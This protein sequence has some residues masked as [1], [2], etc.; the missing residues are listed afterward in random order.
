ML[1]NETNMLI[2]G[3]TGGNK[4]ATEQL[5]QLMTLPD[6]VFDKSFEQIKNSIEEAYKNQGV[7][8]EMLQIL[9]ENPSFDVKEEKENIKNILD[10]IDN[11]EDLT[12]NKKEVL[13][14]AITSATEELFNLAN[15]PR[16]KINVKV[17]KLSRLAK[18]PTYAH[19]TDAGAD[20]YSLEKVVIEPHTTTLVK[21]GIA[22]AVP[23][24]YEI[25]IRP[26]SGLS[27]KTPLRV[28]N[29]PGTI[30]SSYRGEVCVIMENTGNST[31][32]IE[33]GDRIAQMLI[34]P[35]PM[36]KWEEVNELDETDR[37]QGGFG[38]SGS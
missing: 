6:E 21:T 12:A 25:Q 26:R 11:L 29:A 27:L 37:G 18:L 19:P 2:S 10:E 13:K 24:G 22:V 38:S 35:V 15:N 34:V 4:D 7:Q 5:I 17:K 20:I 31:Q 28:A 33:A 23:A 14:I 36:I 32:T 3:I 8:K 30:D 16:E 1:S 9:L